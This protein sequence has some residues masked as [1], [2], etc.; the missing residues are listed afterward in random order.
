MYITQCVSCPGTRC[1]SPSIPLKGSAAEPRLEDWIEPRLQW[2]STLLRVS[3]RNA[4]KMSLPRNRSPSLI[5][6]PCAR[7]P[8]SSGNSSFLLWHLHLWLGTRTEPQGSA[9]GQCFHLALFV[10]RFGGKCWENCPV[11]AFFTCVVGTAFF[12]RLWQRRG[13]VGRW[14][15]LVLEMDSVLY[16]GQYKNYHLF[17]QSFSFLCGGWLF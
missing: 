7:I 15:S 10:V 13:G 3:Y 6:L 17:L 5:F 8:F 11:W 16:G 1:C 14:F 12:Y 2:T 9:R 4:F